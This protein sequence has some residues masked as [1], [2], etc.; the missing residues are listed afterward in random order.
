[1]FFYT[2]A[3]FTSLVWCS[4]SNKII[5]IR[6]GYR[7]PKHSR[8]GISVVYTK[9]FKQHLLSAF[10]PKCLL[11]VAESHMK[12]N[13]RPVLLKSF[14]DR[15]VKLP[16]L[17]LIHLIKQCHWEP[18]AKHKTSFFPSVEECTFLKKVLHYEHP[19]L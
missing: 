5:K 4:F 16:L 12:V 10:S 11:R 13:R 18:E 6:S 3:Y 17:I 2:K 1:M 14:A 15:V 19:Y 9:F 8:L 7:N